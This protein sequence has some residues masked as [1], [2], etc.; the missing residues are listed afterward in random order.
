[1]PSLPASQSSS[2]NFASV[3][4]P[5]LAWAMGNRGTGR[6][7]IE[8]PF[9]L[10]HGWYTEQPCTKFETFEHRKERTGLRHEFIVLKL[11]DG[12]V[13][14]IE[15]T[16]DPN[17]RFDALSHQGSIAY[18]MAQCFRPKDIDQACLLTSDIVTE[19]TLPHEFDIMDVLKICRA[20]HEGAKTR[21]YTLQVFNC[22]FFSLTIQACLT[23]HIT[24]WD[25]KNFFKNWLSQLN[26]GFGVLGKFSQSSAKATSNQLKNE[27]ILFRLYSV[28]NP[29]KPYS[30]CKRSLT[31]KL[32]TKFQRRVDHA[33]YEQKEL[34]YCLNNLL[35]HATIE[36]S[37]KL[38]LEAKLREVFSEIIKES[39]SRIPVQPP[40][41][42]PRTAK[43]L[44]DRLLLQLERLLALNTL[45]PLSPV[46]PTT[47]TKAFNTPKNSRIQS[48]GVNEQVQSRKP[49]PARPRQRTRVLS[50]KG[51]PT[52]QITSTQEASIDWQQWVVLCF[53]YFCF[54]LLHTFDNISNINILSPRTSATLCDLIDEKLDYMLADLERLE[55][56]TFTDLERFVNQIGTLIENPTAVWDKNPWTD[57]YD[58]VRKH[59]LTD[60]HQEI[61]NKNQNIKIRSKEHPK[62]RAVSIPDFQSRILGRIRAHAKDVER[63]WLGSATIIEVE[64]ESMIFQVWKLLHEDRSINETAIK[65]KNGVPK[66]NFGNEQSSLNVTAILPKAYETLLDTSSFLRPIYGTSRLTAN[67]D[68]WRG[69]IARWFPTN[70][71]ASGTSATDHIAMRG[72]LPPLAAI[73]CTY[74]MPSEPNST[75][76]VTK[77]LG[78]SVQVEALPPLTL[79][80]SSISEIYDTP[81]SAVQNTY[82]AGAAKNLATA[83]AAASP[84]SLIMPGSNA[85]TFSLNIG[86]ILD[87]RPSVPAAE[88]TPPAPIQSSTA[89]SETKPSNRTG[90]PGSQVEEHQPSAG[91]QLSEVALDPTADLDNDE[92]IFELAELAT[93]MPHQER[94][95][96]LKILC[97]PEGK[98][99]MK[100]NIFDKALRALRFKPQA[101][102]G[103]KIEYTPDPRYFGLR[104][105]PI[106]FYRPHLGSNYKISN[107]KMKAKSDSFQRQY[108]AAVAVLCEVWGLVD[109]RQQSE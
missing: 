20:I 70:P 15:R 6:L 2:L 24:Y 29:H 68:V 96:W 27:P 37:L 100:W 58:R 4:N 73:Q 47:A 71:L 46:A 38:F 43:E 84:V 102:G 98:S 91:V 79:P 95:L 82:H 44:K 30:I 80:P 81:S 67:I 104:A 57:F 85:R 52:I 35:W 3:C 25:D 49:H 33:E 14:R 23:R 32:K 21:N 87:A 41:D 13:C 56:I 34:Q 77:R 26:H 10:D 39:I 51:T 62:L 107:L 90:K 106:S 109:S 54:W 1:M 45:P 53:P 93:E 83:R 74:S 88:V 92:W 18:D 101:M 22:Y 12:S 78:H 65:M 11:L 86:Q 42:E 60:T 17:A 9:P 19:V 31:D 55:A 99:K 40:A 75:S 105:Q 97:S 16:G 94:D 61:E 48:R 66:T 59:M 108:S 5:S 72:S 63:A 7:I 76:P 28:L 64:L 69:Y 89:K 50:F 103:G 36:P 8:F